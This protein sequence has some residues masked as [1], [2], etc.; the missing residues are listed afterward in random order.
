[1]K[2]LTLRKS[3]VW[4]I[5]AAL[6]GMGTSSAME[7]G[8]PVLEAYASSY[9][10]SYEEARD[11]LAMINPVEMDLLEKQLSALPGYVGMRIVHKPELRI[12]VF[13]DGNATQLAAKARTRVP[14]EPVNVPRSIAQL[15][16]E[17][18]AVSAVLRSRKIGHMY[19]FDLPAGRIEFHIE[20]KTTADRELLN[21]LSS[22]SAGIRIT[23]VGSV[24]E[25]TAN[26]VG[27]QNV[28]GSQSCTSGFTVY[29]ISNPAVRGVITAGHCTDSN[30]SSVVVNGVNFSNPQNRM[31][32]GN[33]DQMWFTQAGHT[34]TNTIATGQSEP[35][36][37]QINATASPQVGLFLCKFGQTTLQ[38]CGEVIQTYAQVYNPDN[39]S[40]GSWILVKNILLGP[41]TMAGDSGGPVFGSGG[42]ALGIV[43]GRGGQGSPNIDNMFFA[44]VSRFGAI[45]VSILTTN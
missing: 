28:N 35:A 8:D 32:L 9:D 24:M 38:T 15:E 5:T 31:Y 40:T 23:Y 39:N 43:I 33:Y 22:K 25:E 16:Q 3:M 21:S 17:A 6:F 20:A 13:A 2:V 18:T 29:R 42:V 14:I 44:P 30:Q 11:R 45:N 12:Q 26:F 37:I 1:M 36:T 4:G 27:G 19:Y 10:L 34:W 41:M 7:Q